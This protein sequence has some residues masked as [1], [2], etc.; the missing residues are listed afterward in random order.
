MYFM[1]STLTQ[2]RSFCMVI[3]DS[4]LNFIFKR[5]LILIYKNQLTTYDHTQITDKEL[6]SIYTNSI[7]IVL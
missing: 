5:D 1:S 2:T 7:Y 3:V 6:N 4:T